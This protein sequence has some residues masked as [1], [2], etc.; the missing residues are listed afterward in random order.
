MTKKFSIKKLVAGVLAAAMVVTA[1]PVSGLSVKAAADPATAAAEAGGA[2]MCAYNPN[3]GE[4]LFTVYKAEYDANVALGYV[5]EGAKWT[6]PEKSGTPLYRVYNPNSGEH[7]LLPEAEVAATVAA[8]WSNEGVK[9]YSDEN[10]GVP[11]YRLFN[12]N[13]T[14]AGSHHYT[15]NQQEAAGLAA[16]GWTWEYNQQPVFY[17]VGEDASS[18]I[19]LVDET[20]LQNNGTALTTDTLKVIYGSSLG[21]PNNITWFCNGAVKTIWS[22]ENGNLTAAS[23]NSDLCRDMKNNTELAEGDWYVTIENTAGKTYTSNKIVVAEHKGAIMSGVGFED[24]Y[25]SDLNVVFDTK[26][27]KAVVDFTL[28]KQYGG[29]LYIAENNTTEWKSSSIGTIPTKSIQ[30]LATISDSTWEDNT[31]MKDVKKESGLTNKAVKENS[32]KILYYSDKNGA[33]HCKVASTATLTRG[34]DYALVF[35]QDDVDGDEFT[36]SS[37]KEDLNI[38][39]KATM[40]YVVEPAS[41]ALTTFDANGSSAEIT[42]YDSNK[43]VLAWWGNGETPGSGANKSNTFKATGNKVSGLEVKL[44]NPEK[45]EVSDDDDPV[46]IAKVKVDKGVITTSNAALTNG[47]AYAK[48]KTDKGIFAKESKTYTATLGE[49][50]THAITGLE[51]DQSGDNP[52]DAKVTLKNLKSKATGTVV[53]VQNKNNKITTDALGRAGN[54]FG[55]AGL[56]AKEATKDSDLIVGM[57]RVTNGTTEV[58]IK[59]VFDSDQIKAT[60]GTNMFAVGFLPD[61]TTTWS[62]EWAGAGNGGDYTSAGT[63]PKM[64]AYEDHTYLNDKLFVLTQD[65]ESYKIS[66]DNKKITMTVATTGTAIAATPTVAI[67]GVDQFGEEYILGGGVTLAALD[68]MDATEDFAPSSA[69]VPKSGASATVVFNNAGGFTLEIPA[70]KPNKDEVAKISLPGDQKLVITCK[71]SDKYEITIE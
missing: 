17:G 44:Y 39:D 40:P 32:G 18:E 51:M 25:E 43:E 29:K 2:V 68:A 59:D 36:L 16:V 5:G 24:D 4:H 41:I 10:K 47:Y 49:S 11:V 66:T 38:S 7:L 12:P 1:F 14:R 71:G 50:A 23:F 70:A 60:D 3:N 8:G 22:L 20:G 42:M 58:I 31:N 57:A 65:L 27:D 69:S 52:A 21:T 62:K 26:T 15:T 64:G 28:N 9:M 46:T 48:I 55:S 54:G 56:L 37:K 19:T 34:T 33:V 53:I 61:D 30:V 35:V 63:D 6:A 45:N 13:E 67:K